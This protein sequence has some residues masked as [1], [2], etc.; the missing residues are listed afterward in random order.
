MIA[1]MTDKLKTL[2]SAV[3]NNAILDGKTVIPTGFIMQINAFMAMG[4]VQGFL[5]C[6]CFSPLELT[7]K[8]VRE[9]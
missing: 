6:F 3:S 2:C 9:D 1:Y 5:C 4:G 8:W 7:G